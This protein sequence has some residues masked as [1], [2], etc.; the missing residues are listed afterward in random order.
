M[1]TR[2]AFFEVVETLSKQTTYDV[3]IKIINDKRRLKG[4]VLTLVIILCLIS[5]C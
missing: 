2:S 4:A 1:T 5:L 3:N